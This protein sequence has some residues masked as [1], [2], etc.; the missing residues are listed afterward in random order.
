VAAKEVLAKVAL[1]KGDLAAAAARREQ[2]VAEFL[3]HVVETH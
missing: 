1:G 3:H 2:T